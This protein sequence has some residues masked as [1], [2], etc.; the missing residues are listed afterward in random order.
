VF[1]DV[2]EIK[3]TKKNEI[4]AYNYIRKD[5][6]NLRE[7]F[8]TR[9]PN[10]PVLLITFNFSSRFFTGYTVA[11]AMLG[12]IGITYNKITGETSGLHFLPKGN[13]KLTSKHNRV[14]SGVFI[15][16]ENSKH[17]LFKNPFADN[18]IEDNYFPGTIIIKIDRSLTNENIMKLSKI[19]F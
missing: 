11:R 1:C 4:D 7:K 2:K 3:H 14:I 8:K 9:R 16:Q 19:Q 12:D 13:A 6:Q 15:F 10:D 5:I 18:P 17:Y